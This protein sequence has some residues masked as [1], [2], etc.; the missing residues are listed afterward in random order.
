MATQTTLQAT[1]TT[2]VSSTLADLNLSANPIIVVGT[3]PV[4]GNAISY[5]KFDLSAL[6][7]QTASSAILRLF[8]FVKTGGTPTPITVN[9]ALSD[10]NINTVTYNSQP[11]FVQ[12]GSSTT[13]SDEDVLQY[14][15][16]DITELIN[17]WLNQTFPNFGMALAGTDGTTSVQFGGRSIGPAFEPQLV[18]TTESPSSVSLK[19]IQAQ[20]RDSVSEILD[21]GAVVPFDT[22]VNN[23]SSILFNAQTGTFTLTAAGNYYIKWWVTTDGSAGPVNMSFTVYTDGI[24]AIGGNSPIVTGQVNGDA[25]LIFVDAPHDITLVNTTG[26]DVLF[27]NIPT[28]ANIT[29]LTVE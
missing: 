20:L 29:I 18:V 1:G 5:L 4:Y 15:E 12:T 24:S 2:F 23:Q 19:G 8:V 21:D 3:S 22:L 27:A 13:V 11:L 16:I 17:Q 26:A 25:F 9:R 28:Q 14:I 6:A 10:F 7:G